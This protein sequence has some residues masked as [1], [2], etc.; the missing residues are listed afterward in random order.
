MFG[1]L[2]S[3]WNASKFRKEEHFGNNVGVVSNY[4]MDLKYQNYEFRPLKQLFWYSSS[5]AILS[6]RKQRKRYVQMTPYFV[7]LKFTL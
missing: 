5:D 2:I 6:D 4:I 1:N 3:I 7:L